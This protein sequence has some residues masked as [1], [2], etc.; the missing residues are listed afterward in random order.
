M[1]EVDFYDGLY[2]LYRKV[3]ALQLRAIADSP[4]D[5]LS[6][7]EMLVLRAI[8]ER[9]EA[10]MSEIAVLVHVTQGTLTVT[11]NRLVKKG[12]VMRI[13]LESDRRIVKTALTRKGMGA[14]REDKHFRAQ[15][16]EMVDQQLGSKSEEILEDIEQLCACMDQHL[17][18]SP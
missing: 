4:Y 7:S 13:R 18:I 2:M 1:S 16:Q 8:S 3:H 12:Y 5:D 17:E 11:V 15:I 10:T 14:V 9:E 6:S